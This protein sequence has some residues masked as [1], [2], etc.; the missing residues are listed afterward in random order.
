M[1]SMDELRL[2][3]NEPG[4]TADLNLG[5]TPACGCG[6]LR[7]FEFFDL[8]T[9]LTMRDEAHGKHSFPKIPGT[10]AFSRR[11]GENANCVHYIRS[12]RW[13]DD[14]EEFVCPDCSHKHGWWLPKRGLVECCGCH[15]QT[16]PTAGTLFHRSHVPLCKWFWVM[17]LLANR[18]EGVSAVDLAEQADI[19][20]QTAWT[21]LHKLREAM[22]QRCEL[23]GHGGLARI[24]ET[25]AKRA[26][27]DKYHAVS[28]KHMDKYLAAI[29]FRVHGKGKKARFFDRLVAAAVNA[30]PMTFNDLTAEGK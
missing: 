30:G 15:R 26:I 14:L 1:A 24:A 16:S 3:G 13:G 21:M 17:D 8:R 27:L 29:M 18:P 12:M 20:Y 22:R 23:D 7:A 28:P 5:L 2:L 11:F 19:T 10:A 6:I 9:R 4:K 25:D